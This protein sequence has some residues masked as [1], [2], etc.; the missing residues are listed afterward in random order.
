MSFGGS[1][2]AMIT[3]LRSNNNL[4]MNRVKYFDKD[5]KNIQSELANR[6]PLTYKHLTQK[7]ILEI[8]KEI[9]EKNKVETL[10]KITA[11]IIALLI[12][13]V[14]AFLFVKYFDVGGFISWLTF[15]K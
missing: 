5:T 13:T 12:T 15:K 1:V 9:T 3:S 6:K 8:R 7:E 4:R 11:V 2:S 10:K 14:I